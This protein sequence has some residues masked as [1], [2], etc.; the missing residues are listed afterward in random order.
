[1]V[2]RM[3]YWARTTAPSTFI[4][5]ARAFDT[6]VVDTFCQRL[7]LPDLT[8]AA[9]AQIELPVGVGGFGLTSLV[10][11][12]PAAWYCAFAQAFPTIRPHI[13][14]LDTL[15]DE[16]PF[17]LTLS[18]CFTYF[19]KYTFPRGSPISADIHRFWLDYGQKRVLSGAQRLIMAAIY[20]ARKEIIFNDFNRDSPDRARLNSISAPFAGSW[21][22]TL[23]IDPLFS[24]HDIH[25]ALASR[26]R[27]GLA[28]FDDVNRCI[29]GVSTVQS[30]FHFSV[31]QTQWG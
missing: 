9:R 23:P 1:M 14:S 26:L 17:V 4:A 21:L 16:V 12:S 13:L 3:N 11:V 2:P 19:S 31:L 24:I 27:L 6:L 8:D 29:C 28:L 20:K 22:T 15:S 10:L 7:K 25:F 18:Q 5:A 30:P